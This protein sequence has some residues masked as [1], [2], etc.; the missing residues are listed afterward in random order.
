MLPGVRSL[1]SVL[2]AT[3]IEV[4]LA[5]TPR[6]LQD[7]MD[8]LLASLNAQHSKFMARHPT[9]KARASWLSLVAD[10]VHLAWASKC[11][12]T[13]HCCQNELLGR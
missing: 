13:W 2:H 6:H 11:S 3:A 4:L 5:L 12:Q 1:R 9:F 10:L 8:S 7:M